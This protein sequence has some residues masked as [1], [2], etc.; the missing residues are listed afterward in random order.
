MT[1]MSG[2]RRVILFTERLSGGV[3]HAVEQLRRSSLSRFRHL[4][5]D[6]INTSVVSLGNLLSSYSCVVR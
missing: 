2:V 5:T 6:E 3:G 1:S 4:L